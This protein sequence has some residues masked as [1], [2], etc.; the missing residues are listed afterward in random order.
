MAPLFT[1]TR[2]SSQYA[3][4]AE[5]KAGPLFYG[6]HCITKGVVGLAISSEEG[7]D[8]IPVDAFAQFVRM[9]LGMPRMPGYTLLKYDFYELSF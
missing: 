8:E 6:T 1:T 4:L 2:N 9:S 7:A 5:E 3:K